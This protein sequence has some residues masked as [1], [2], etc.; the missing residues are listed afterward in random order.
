M[1]GARRA[2]VDPH[3]KVVC[4]PGKARAEARHGNER[5]SPRW[6]QLPQMAAEPV[7]GPREVTE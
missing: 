6:I 1:P 3:E 7:G 2:F 5:V 4:G